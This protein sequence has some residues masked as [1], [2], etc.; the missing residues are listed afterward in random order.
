MDHEHIIL[1]RIWHQNAIYLWKITSLMWNT[2]LYIYLIGMKLRSLMLMHVI[3]YHSKE[4]I[5]STLC[6]SCRQDFN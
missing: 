5:L 3:F 2:E 4:I 1:Y 6:V